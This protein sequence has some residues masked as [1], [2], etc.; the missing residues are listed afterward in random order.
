MKPRQRLR[1]L[2]A[3]AW[4]LRAAT[5]ARRQLSAGRM[6][7]LDLPRVPPRVPDSAIWGV[8]AALRPRLFTCLVRASVRQA[9][10]S[11][12]GWQRDL[13]IGVKAPGPDFEAHA[14]L[15]GDDPGTA[16]AYHELTR[17]AAV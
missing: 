16:G 8:H 6:P 1:S 4:A 15:E 14:W 3:A 11:A 9:W 10:H 5:S 17:R 13:I 12:H 7:P 2:L